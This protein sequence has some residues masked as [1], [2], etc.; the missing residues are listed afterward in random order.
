MT[1][2]QLVCPQILSLHLSCRQMKAHR[3]CS[4]F[5]FN[6]THS[7]LGGKLWSCKNGGICQISMPL[8]K[9]SVLL[10]HKCPMTSK[11]HSTC[12]MLILSISCMEPYCEGYGKGQCCIPLL[13]LLKMVSSYHTGEWV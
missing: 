8:Q 9:S 3:P 1:N 13:K 5:L 2:L 6:H 7:G 12:S 10:Q 11:I 4:I